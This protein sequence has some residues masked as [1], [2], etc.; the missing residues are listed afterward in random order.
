[1]LVTSAVR[2]SAVRCSAVRCWSDVGQMLVM[3]SPA[4]PL[5][6]TSP[7]RF[8]QSGVPSL[9]VPTRPFFLSSTVKP[10]AAASSPACVLAFLSSSASA[11]CHW[12]R[13]ASTGTASERGAKRE[14][15]LSAPPSESMARGE[16]RLDRPPGRSTGTTR[17]SA[18]AICAAAAAASTIDARRAG[19]S[20]TTSTTRRA[21]PRPLRKSER[22]TNCASPL[23]STCARSAAMM[24]PCERR[25]RRASRA[26][27]SLRHKYPVPAIDARST[28]RLSAVSPAAGRSPAASASSDVPAK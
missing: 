27:F 9:R 11:A 13:S 22:R 19:S 23:P 14:A 6:A 26:A 16:A 1:M 4:A 25:A 21:S 24:A 12:G 5:L 10:R 17:K 20:A 28:P 18:D 2:C 7:T 8:C 3:S 15:R